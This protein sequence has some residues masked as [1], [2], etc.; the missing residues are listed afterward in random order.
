MTL[1]NYLERIRTKR[2]M[3]VGAVAIPSWIAGFVAPKGSTIQIVGIVVFLVAVLV[4]VVS[5][6]RIKCP[7]CGKPLGIVAQHQR[8]FGERLM[9]V[10]RCRNCGFGLDEEIPGAPRY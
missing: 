7:R 5:V 8:R 4:G 9:R 10:D 6:G 3:A 1:R 2:F